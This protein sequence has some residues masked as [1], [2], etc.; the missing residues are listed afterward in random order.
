MLLGGLFQPRLESFASPGFHLL[1]LLYYCC[2]DAF[3]LA[4]SA[5]YLCGLEGRSFH[6]LG[7]AFDAGWLRQAAVG[8]A[9]GAAVI[10]GTALLLVAARAGTVSFVSLNPLSHFLSVVAFL[11][12]AAAFEELTFRGYA[13]QRAAQALGPFAAGL[14]ASLL[15]GFAHSGNPQATL[16]STFNTILAGALLAIARIRTRAL[17]MPIG[18]H[19]GWN[20]FLGPVFS[21]PVSGYSFGGAALSASSAGLAWLSGGAYGPEGGA[22]LTAILAV[23]I[24]LALRRTPPASWSSFRADSGVD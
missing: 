9:W 21:F 12:L 24:P 7:L 23:A 17:W 10:S 14:L 8:A 4:L 18:L 6:T 22:A 20:L 3:V 15:F 1:P 11:L 5:A 16:L 13:F 19:F 2:L